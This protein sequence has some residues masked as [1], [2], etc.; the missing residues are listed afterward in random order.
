[1]R[2][3]LQRYTV[4]E[5][6]GEGPLGQVFRVRDEEVGI[7]AAL[8]V[9]HRELL[10]TPR[11]EE[12]FLRRMQELRVL[13]HRNLVRIFDVGRDEI[14]F[15]VTQLLQGVPL[16]Q[17]MEFRRSK[18]KQFTIEEVVP[19]FDQLAD[20]LSG[21][22]STTCH[23]DLKPR[24]LWILPELLKVTDA[25][26]V[27]AI[28][29]GLGTSRLADDP[30]SKRYAAPEVLEG[31]LPSTRTDVYSAAVI[32]TEL[33]TGSPY[34]GRWSLVKDLSMNF[35]DA[36]AGLLSSA[37][38]KD[39]EE[40]PATLR[41]LADELIPYAGRRT[42][43]GGS[44]RRGVRAHAPAPSGEEAEPASDLTSA[45]LEATRKTPIPVVERPAETRKRAKARPIEEE[46][47]PKAEVTQ[48]VAMADVIREFSEK[49]APVVRAAPPSQRAPASG[50]AA[51]TETREPS[52]RQAP[53]RP[54]APR[55]AKKAKVPDRSTKR[56]YPLEDEESAG[57]SVPLDEVIA[58]AAEP[59][60]KREITQEI[61][62]EMIEEVRVVR[63]AEK[64]AKEK[65][66]DRGSDLD[67]RLVR[68]ASRLDKEKKTLSPREEAEAEARKRAKEGFDPRLL[69]A[70]TRLE[71]AR[72]KNREQGED[73]VEE[74][75]VTD[76]EDED[77]RKAI[78]AEAGGQVI[79]F[80]A[81]P[82]MENR[83]VVQGFPKA[84]SRQMVAPPQPQLLGQPAPGP[85]VRREGIRPMAPVMA[86]QAPRREER[87]P[88]ARPQ[89]MPMPAAQPPRKGSTV[90]PPPPARRP[91]DA[92][93][94]AANVPLRPP[95]M[96]PPKRR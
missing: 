79:S 41:D 5:D 46:P 69:R 23:G 53:A 73:A 15:V 47:E 45:V 76:P 9:I 71:E 22:G 54:V 62:L 36:V 3:I 91:K 65:K 52:V 40:R 7:E 81:P 84:Q 21:I 78:E 13:G 34:P 26:L 83:P 33:A 4:L 31:E 95:P 8:K 2:Q 75:E 16:Q 51:K 39:G 63:Q 35:P 70:A 44:R 80:L 10:P 93:R 94:G 49:S 18:A 14:C 88:A 1:M 59:K 67:P 90:P 37:L 72:I 27:T 77:W 24:N 19:I 96:P 74:I 17:L 11:S 48:E 92:G 61:S 56:I 38:S 43:T 6:I 50:G 87:R 64:A 42:S 57:P 32:L 86:P 28:P 85:A 68:A 60:A 20:L 66:R 89:P 82:T 55:P 30:G 58:R 12:S 25:G 29:M